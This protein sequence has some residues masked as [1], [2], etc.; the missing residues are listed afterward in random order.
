MIVVVFLDRS[1]LL[2]SLILEVDR[3]SCSSKSEALFFSCARA[4]CFSRGVP[5]ATRV[6][7][8]SKIGLSIDLYPT[9]AGV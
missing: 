4:V 3:E 8:K 9:K 5:V 7:T 2:T 1:L 6:A